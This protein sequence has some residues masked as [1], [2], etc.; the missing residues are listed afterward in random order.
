MIPVEN[1]KGIL[2]YICEDVQRS[3]KL[4]KY[5]KDELTESFGKHHRRLNNGEFNFFAWDIE[6]KG[7]AYTVYTHSHKGT[8]IEIDAEY[9]DDKSNEIKEF[10]KYIEEKL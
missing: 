10:L 5:S 7:E 4:T 6:F 3:I 9:N 8:C 2:S 1:Y